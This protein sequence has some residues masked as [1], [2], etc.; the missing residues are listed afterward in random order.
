MSMNLGCRTLVLALIAGMASASPALAQPETPNAGAPTAPSKL[1]VFQT[2]V[3]P[4]AVSRQ[5][6]TR[7]AAAYMDDALALL[8]MAQAHLQAGDARRASIE[9]TAASG[10]LTDA[11]LFGFHDRGFSSR[12]QPLTLQASRAAAVAISDPQMAL[13]LVNN[14]QPAVASIYTSQYASLGGGAGMGGGGG[15]GMTTMQGFT[16]LRSPQDDQDFATPPGSSQPLP[17]DEE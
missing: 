14:V 7:A 10:K 2:H 17:S 15:G 12:V 9:L 11:Y 13:S 5:A 1:S 6:A 4:L 3:P 8:D 16:P